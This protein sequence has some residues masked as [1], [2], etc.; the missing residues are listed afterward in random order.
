MEEE[1]EYKDEESMK[2]ETEKIYLNKCILLSTVDV[3]NK[4]AKFP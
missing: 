1:S 4:Q 2:V 3:E